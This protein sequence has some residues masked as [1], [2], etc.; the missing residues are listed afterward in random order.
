MYDM[1]TKV[2]TGRV[3]FQSQIYAHTIS[4]HNQYLSNVVLFALAFKRHVVRYTS[5]LAYAPNLSTLSR[6]INEQH[7]TN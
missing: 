6:G 1:S 7:Y 2:D 4:T 3:V 5:Q